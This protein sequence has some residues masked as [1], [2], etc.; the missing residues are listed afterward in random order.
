MARSRATAAHSTQVDNLIDP[1]ALS[2]RNQPLPEAVHLNVRITGDDARILEYLQRRTPGISDS[3][4][5]RDCIRTAVFL[6]AMRERG[7]PVTVPD[8]NAAAFEVLEHL[9]VF[10]P[11]VGA[12]PARTKR[13]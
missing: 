12:K 5:V 8:S 3:L 2:K 7:T 11:E 13:A 6:F 1:H 10:M 9:G 4:R